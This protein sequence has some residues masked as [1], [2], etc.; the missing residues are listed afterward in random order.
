[1]S[2][3][4]YTIHLQPGPSQAPT[5]VLQGEF[6]LASKPDM[7]TCFQ[8]VLATG[9]PVLNVDLA[10]VSF[11]DSAALGV[12]VDAFQALRDR[13]GHLV[14]TAASTFAVRT[15]EIAGLTPYLLPA[16][17]DGDGATTGS[18]D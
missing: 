8:R 17:T 16:H 4:F 7:E 14:V 3:P 11:I 15:L 10:E 1:M 5:L 13:D 12:L 9:P 2:S 18:A 6:D